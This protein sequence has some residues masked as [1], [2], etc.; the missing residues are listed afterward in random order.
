MYTSTHIHKYTTTHWWA[1]YPPR[2]YMFIR[3]YIHDHICTHDVYVY[4]YIHMCTSTHIHRY[5]ATQSW[6]FYP[7]RPNMYTCVNVYICKWIHMYECIH[8]STQSHIHKY[9]NFVMRYLFS[10]TLRI[11]MYT[12][13]QVYT[14]TYI[15]KY[16]YVHI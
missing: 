11:D 15:H 16:I 7:P 6:T 13:V 4:K 9:D 14:Y 12:Y 5:M 3:I 8:T 1:F 2:P 10:T